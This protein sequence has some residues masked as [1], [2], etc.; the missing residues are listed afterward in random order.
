MA[1]KAIHY[2]QIPSNQVEE[3]GAEN[4]HVRWVINKENDG[5]KNFAMR[6]FEIK[7]G[8]YTPRHSHNWEHEVYI[9][10]GEGVVNYK[11]SEEHLKPGFIVFVP[12]NIKHQFR[13]SGKKILRFLCL[14]PYC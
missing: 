9:L 3:S 14:I 12:P 8:G 1:F 4:V 13:N 11:S 2:K 6:V 7:T 5:A 10:E